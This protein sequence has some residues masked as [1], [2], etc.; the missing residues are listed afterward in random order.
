MVKIKIILL[1]QA[2]DEWMSWD[3]IGL[4]VKDDRHK[5]MWRYCAEH[6]FQLGAIAD[7]CLN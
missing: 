3:D 6:S 2:G 7:Y 4:E 5:L 1:G